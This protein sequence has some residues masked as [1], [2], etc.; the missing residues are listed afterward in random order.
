MLKDVLSL[1]HDIRAKERLSD[2]FHCKVS[3]T[4][5]Y[6]QSKSQTAIVVLGATWGK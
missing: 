6:M 3:R 1:G 5:S 2:V 4:A